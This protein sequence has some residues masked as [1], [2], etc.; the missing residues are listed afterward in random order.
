MTFILP[1]KLKDYFG[2]VQPPKPCGSN[3]S[4]AF[5][6][7]VFGFSLTFTPIMQC[8]K[9]RVLLCLPLPKE[10]SKPY[11]SSHRGHGRKADEDEEQEDAKTNIAVH[12][13]GAQHG[14][15]HGWVRHRQ[16]SLHSY[17]KFCRDTVRGQTQVPAGKSYSLC[18]SCKWLC[19]NSLG[20]PTDHPCSFRT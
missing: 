14:V 20:E 5:K 10:T 17:F 9:L 18:K 16:S 13:P 3:T 15:G 12:V 8:G 19:V 1:S 7:S 6:H 2:V 11:S 4:H